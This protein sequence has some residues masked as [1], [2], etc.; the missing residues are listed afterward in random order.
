MYELVQYDRVIYIC[1]PKVSFLYGGKIAEA[2]ADAAQRSG[3]LEKG[4]RDPQ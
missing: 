2:D 4:L 3:T 1:Y